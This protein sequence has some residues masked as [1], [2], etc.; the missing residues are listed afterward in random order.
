V[1]TVEIELGVAIVKVH[2]RHLEG[3]R[4]ALEFAVA[5]GNAD[6]THVV[7][8]GEQQ[9]QNH[10]AILAE[11]FGVQRHF[12]ILCHPGDARRLEPRRPFHL[13]QAQTARTEARQTGEMTQGGNEHII[14]TRHLK[15]GLIAAG[16]HFL[17]VKL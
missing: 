11:P 17:P 15:N 5:I 2:V 10:S 12:H 13:H 6:R 16:A 7:S 4:Q 3:L 14:L 8:F 9:F 1:G